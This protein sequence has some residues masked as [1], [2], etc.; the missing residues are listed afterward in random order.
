MKIELNLKPKLSQQAEKEALKIARLT[1][2]KYIKEGEIPEI[3]PKNKE[4]YLPI[5]AFVTLKKSGKLRGCLGVFFTKEPLYKTIIKQTIAA[6]T[7]D[8]RFFPVK[9]DE[10]KNIKIE[11]SLIGPLKRIDDWRKIKLGEDGVLIRLGGRG[12]TFLPEVAKE[13]GWDLETFLSVLCLEKAGLPPD[14]Y[15]Y[16]ET[17]IYIY[18]THKIEEK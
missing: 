15:K 12:G 17:E 3:K 4:L 16:P 10:L 7:Q 11:I 5:G 13:T 6:A 1:L 8:P 2:E 14:C 18:K 9:E